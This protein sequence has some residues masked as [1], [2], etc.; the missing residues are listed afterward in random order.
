M[1]ADALAKAKG[2]PIAEIT[3]R[4]EGFGKGADV[5]PHP[6]YV[7]GKQAKVTIKG[8][9][10][11]SGQVE[12]RIQS[13]EAVGGFRAVPQM[14]RSVDPKLH[15]TEIQPAA[16]KFIRAQ[17]VSAA[18]NARLTRAASSGVPMPVVKTCP[19]S[20]QRDPATSTGEL[21]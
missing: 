8:V 4:G 12:P 20:T 19:E 16:D 10:L 15:I 18:W 21:R 6:A 1:S 2:V 13:V 17:P 14:L 11:T 3:A 7:V 5:I 9:K